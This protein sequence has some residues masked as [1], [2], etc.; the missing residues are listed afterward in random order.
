MFHHAALFHLFRRELCPL[1]RWNAS[2]NRALKLSREMHGEESC[3]TWQVPYFLPGGPSVCKQSQLPDKGFIIWD[4][5][6]NHQRTWCKKIS[7]HTMVINCCMLFL[8]TLDPEF[9]NGKIACHVFYLVDRE[10]F[11][12]LTMILPLSLDHKPAWT[13]PSFPS[14]W[15]LQRT[16]HFFF[17]GNK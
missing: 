1:Q 3:R 9:C 8:C 10:H 2:F 14:T 5:I 13:G 12:L 17:S 16:D 7:H 15:E 4:Y 6:C 11:C